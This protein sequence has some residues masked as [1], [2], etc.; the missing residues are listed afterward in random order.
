LSEG[1]RSAEG[2]TTQLR[3]GVWERSLDLT[4]RHDG[5][6]D[7]VTV[8]ENGERLASS[9]FGAAQAASSQPLLVFDREG[10]ALE[11]SALAAVDPVAAALL[12]P[13]AWQNIDASFSALS[14]YSLELAGSNSSAEDAPLL[15]TA[16]QALS[17]GSGAIN[18]GGLNAWGCWSSCCESTCTAGHYEPDCCGRL[19]WVCDARSCTDPCERCIWPY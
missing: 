8:E 6:F 16:T 19:I 17:I 2:S 9:T 15:G 18:T 13:A 11:P 12:T 10:R 7:T 14:D 1:T 3:V 5:S 4:R